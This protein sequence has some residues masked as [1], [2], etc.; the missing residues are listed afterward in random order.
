MMIPLQQEQMIY[1]SEGRRYES[2]DPDTFFGKSPERD[3]EK[4]SS[5]LQIRYSRH[6][7]PVPPEK[8]PTRRDFLQSH[9][10]YKKKQRAFTTPSLTVFDFDDDE[11][12]SRDEKGGEDDQ[13]P[14]TSTTSTTPPGQDEEIQIHNEKN[15]I[16]G[17]T[18]QMLT[19]VMSKATIEDKSTISP[20]DSSATTTATKEASTA[21][22][23]TPLP[24]ASE[25]DNPLRSRSR[26][27]RRKKK[28][29]RPN[30]KPSNPTSS[31]ATTHNQKNTTPT[32]TTMPLL[33]VETQGLE[34]ILPSS[35]QEVVV[36]ETQ[37]KEDASLPGT[38]SLPHT[39]DFERIF[40]KPR[41]EEGETQEEEASPP[42][43]RALSLP[44]TEDFQ[45]IFP[46]PPQRSEEDEGSSEESPLQDQ[47]LPGC[48]GE[49]ASL[50]R[51]SES[52]FD[53]RAKHKSSDNSAGDNPTKYSPAEMNDGTPS[54][55]QNAL[56][57]STS[58]PDTADFERIFPGPQDEE[59]LT[60]VEDDQMGAL[61]MASAESFQHINH[62]QTI[63]SE[64]HPPDR[65]L[66]D[67]IA[68]NSKDSA[69]RMNPLQ[70][71]GN[72][73]P[74]ILQ[75][76]SSSLPSSLSQED[77]HRENSSDEIF[78]V[79]EELSPLT[80]S[81]ASMNFDRPVVPRSSQNS[82]GSSQEMKHPVVTPA[83]ANGSGKRGYG[84]NVLRSLVDG[85]HSITPLVGT[86]GKVVDTSPVLNGNFE[87]FEQFSDSR[88]RVDPPKQNWRQTSFSSPC[89]KVAE[90]PYRSASHPFDETKTV[91]ICPRTYHYLS[92]LN[93]ASGI[94]GENGACLW[95]DDQLYHQAKN[96]RPEW[97]LQAPWW[98]SLAKSP[99]NT[100]SS[101]GGIRASMLH[102][103]ECLV[104]SKSIDLSSVMAD[105][106]DL[107]GLEVDR[108]GA[109]IGF[110]SLSSQEVR[111][112]V[113]TVC[114]PW[115]LLVSSHRVCSSWLTF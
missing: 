36:D 46:E 105:D 37:E 69:K 45:R 106:M 49:N 111:S 71:I 2:L 98:N 12:G 3:E 84:G 24:I 65:D 78:A 67:A 1:P 94:V 5:S 72:S 64:N 79:F 14:S 82:Q 50:S 34:Q 61:E 27:R 81:L 89:N 51:Q 86:R 29:A 113:L 77:I 56:M 58:L 88:P 43:H 66:N 102:G 7:P 99:C 55:S 9:P 20:L 53:D 80:Q 33:L 74:T 83:A 91:N 44:Q 32:S 109:D 39:E 38:F 47:D 28:A 115:G 104:I 41:Q 87:N 8:C 42:H 108:C 112:T 97:L 93:S 76:R 103:Y 73:K 100:T 30:A 75:K 59:D 48:E 60:N 101:T 63:R 25:D 4:F 92:A 21:T 17:S 114:T 23:R 18:I 110:R 68:D 96:H 52:T 57:N 11:T 90:F 40:P 95:G 22:S 54:S 70:Q 62:N 107:S 6:G 16:S 19:G 35:R 13:M 10:H 15:D 26:S 31:D 85:S